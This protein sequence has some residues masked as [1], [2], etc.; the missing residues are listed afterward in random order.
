MIHVLYYLLHTQD[1]Q[2]IGDFAEQL[3]RYFGAFLFYAI[4]ATLIFLAGR[5]LYI[6]FSKK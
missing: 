1:A 4:P 5:L 6:K 2:S 3:G